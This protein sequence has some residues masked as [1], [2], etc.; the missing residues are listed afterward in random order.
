MTKRDYLS[1]LEDRAEE[2]GERKPAPP[3]TPP[4]EPVIFVDDFGGSHCAECGTVYGDDGD[5]CP[6]CGEAP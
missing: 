4:P 1:E 6:V 3:P 5:G 2:L